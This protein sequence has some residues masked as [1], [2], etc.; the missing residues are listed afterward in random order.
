MKNYLK[1]EIKSNDIMIEGVYALSGYIKTPCTYMAVCDYYQILS[2]LGLVPK[3][4]SLYD[5]YYSTS[6]GYFKHCMH[7]NNY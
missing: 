5:V 3:V 7:N 1:P 6:K 4:C 2:P